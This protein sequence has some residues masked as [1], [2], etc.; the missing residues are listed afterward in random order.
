[1]RDDA[2]CAHD[3][4]TLCLARSLKQNT[5]FVLGLKCLRCSWPVLV[6]YKAFLQAFAVAF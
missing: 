3:F 4:V 2:A 1:M 6:A 5:V